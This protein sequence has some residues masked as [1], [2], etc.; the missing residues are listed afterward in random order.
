MSV[1]VLAKSD[2]NLQARDELRR[3]G[4]DHVTSRLAR[5]LHNVPLVG[6][7]DVGHVSKSWDV[8]RTVQFIE[9]YVPQGDAILDVGAFASEVLCS[10]CK[11]GF[12]DLTGIDLNPS[13]PR[14]PFNDTIKYVTGDFASTPFGDHSFGAVT[15]I[16]VIEHGFCPNR[17]FREVSR[18][19]K[20]G[21]YFVGSTDY[22]PEKIDTTGITAF[23]MDWTIFSEAELRNVIEAAGD[24]GLLPVGPLNFG[25]SEKTVNWLQ[26]EY[27]F[28]WFALRKVGSGAPA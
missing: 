13:L 28:A 7:V 24:Y 10:L 11:L 12:S 19:L 8:L 6:G 16:S 2:D 14:M 18:I 3:R 25:A 9:Q 20:P 26:R 4:I 15:A 1:E 17:I 5:L 21:G 23:G 22:W 27:T